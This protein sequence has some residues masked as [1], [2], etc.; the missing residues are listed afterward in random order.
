[1]GTMAQEFTVETESV[2]H[3]V[4]MP[5]DRFALPEKV[6]AQLNQQKD[7]P[8]PATPGD[9]PKSGEKNPDKDN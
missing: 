7:A 3:N 2:E 4:D 1:M 5:A 9:P 8:P 6:V